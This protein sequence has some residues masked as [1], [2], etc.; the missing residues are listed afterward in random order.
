MYAHTGA[1]R[2]PRDH[3]MQEDEMKQNEHRSQWLP[4]LVVTAIAV[5]GSVGSGAAEHET[6]MTVDIEAGAI[7]GAVVRDFGTI[8]EGHDAVLEIRVKNTSASPLQ[9]GAVKP[10]CSCMSEQST[11]RIEPGTTG[12]ISLR[13]E[14]VGY[15][16]D[17]TE[18][19]LIEWI[20][21]PV[22][23]TRAEMKMVVQPIIEV[24]PRK[25]IRFRAT[26]GEEATD[27]VTL[28]RADGKPLQVSSVETSAGYLAATVEPL[29][30]GGVQVVVTLGADAPNGILKG[31]VSLH[32]DVPE[33]PVLELK[34]AGLVAK[35]SAL[36]TQSSEVR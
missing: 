16:G 22:A 26:Q 10:L 30:D 23:L 36:D 21:R 32:T 31:T 18:A 28:R 24:S 35:I 7:P 12:T 19:A 2:L 34:V 33:V 13:L 9:V 6:V 25:L 27:Q 17:T 3:V 1:A 29:E 8:V 14:T 11:R 4:V 15:S 20:D 5:A